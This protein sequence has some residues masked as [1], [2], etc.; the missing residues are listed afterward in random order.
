M[1]GRGIAPDGLPPLGLWGKKSPLF[2][3][4]LHQHLLCN[5]AGIFLRSGSGSVLPQRP[6][7]WANALHAFT[8]WLRPD[9]PTSLTIT[10]LFTIQH[11]A[12]QELIFYH[13][14]GRGSHFAS[15]ACCT[16]DEMKSCSLSGHFST[17]VNKADSLP[18][19]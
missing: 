14:E 15:F 3:V 1:M 16:H 11:H 5:N 4:H 2:I 8:S 6:V 18:V 12:M 9:T 19:R 17:I 13:Q 7:V 10:K